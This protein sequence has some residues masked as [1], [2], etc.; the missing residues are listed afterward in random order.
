MLT[1]RRALAAGAS[2]TTLAAAPML[3]SCGPNRTEEDASA[4]LRFAWWGNLTRDE[5]TMAA[6]EEY[7]S[8]A[9]GPTIAAENSDWGGYWDKLAT[10][11]AAGDA[12]D[13]LQMDEKYLTEYGTRGALL[14]LA[15]QGISTDGFEESVVAT[16][17]VEGE[18]LLAMCGG[19]NT[20]VLLANPEV[21]AAAGMDL[22]DDSTW[23]WDELIELGAAI[24]EATDDDTVG[25]AQL[26]LIQNV[27]A[28]LMR[29]LGAEQYDASGPGFTPQQAAE[30]FDV[31]RRL[32]ESGAAPGAELAVEEIGQSLDQTL[33]GR[34]RCAMGTA[35]SNQVV[36]FDEAIGGQAEILRLPSM[37]GSAADVGL[38][39]K[40]GLYYSVS[41]T[42]Q[43]PEEA[44]AF[45]EWL[46]SSADAGRH[47]LAE[48][49]VPGNL[50]V[51]EQILEDLTPSDLKA[52]QFIEDIAEEV[53][54]APPLT[55][56][57]GGQFEDML[58]RATQDMLFGTTDPAA[59]G[60]ALHDEV[61]A[62]T[63]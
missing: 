62:A 34:G 37:T 26:G 50:E 11:V 52:V 5:M 12:P 47:L 39:Y 13:V 53:G 15:E 22:P 61:A 49:G 17:E 16:G 9:P 41:S 3:S 29:Q 35:W 10:Q 32:Q 27:F 38:W 1:R 31:A 60:Q 18:G 36:A 2:L 45:V 25:V 42:T 28:V 44:V 7:G 23:T 24:T 14:D 54:E 51:R 19:I 4:A 30:H 43:H 48:R 20:P 6:I 8:V 55:P 40:S 58:N 21:F 57:G 46:V 33:F 56:P 63:A 59:A